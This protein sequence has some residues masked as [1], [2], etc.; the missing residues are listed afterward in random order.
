MAVFRE[1]GKPKTESK[2]AYERKLK[3]GIFLYSLFALLLI[4]FYTIKLATRAD[5]MN[6]SISFVGNALG[7]RQSLMI[8]TAMSSLFFISFLCYL[9]TLMRQES[10][11]AK[12]M[13]YVAGCTLIACNF[14]PS[15]PQFPVLGR[16]HNF[17]AMSASILLAATLFVFV[18]TLRR[19]DEKIYKKALCLWM[20]IVTIP[21]CLLIRFGV[22]SLLESISIL[23]LCY[24]LFCALLW[25]LKSKAFRGARALAETEAE[26]AAERAKHLRKGRK[27]NGKRQRKQRKKRIGKR[28]R[29]TDCIGRRA[30]RRFCGK[31]KSLQNK[32]EREREESGVVPCA[33]RK[34][35]VK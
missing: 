34:R 8:W 26:Q 21:A 32:T 31:R 7:H 15:V 33:K 9:L 20:L 19:F 10:S 24:F 6:Y 13:I 35:G 18:A 12:G 11:P 22:N 23:L 14:V 17:L 29:Q 28:K 30:W 3:R 16:Y 27:G 1:T 4:P 25:L 2:T 5:V